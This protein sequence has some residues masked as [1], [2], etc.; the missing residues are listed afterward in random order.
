[1]MVTPMFDLSKIVLTALTA[2]GFMIATLARMQ[3]RP[4][5]STLP[6]AHPGSVQAIQSDA[7]EP[8]PWLGCGSIPW[9]N[10]VC[11]AISCR[12][13]KQKPSRR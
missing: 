12:F 2:F 13:G 6:P 4:G 8:L 9:F 1:M 7:R 3:R 10:T 11:L 5:S